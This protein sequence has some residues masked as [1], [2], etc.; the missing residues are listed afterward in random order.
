M[1]F[2][3]LLL[4]PSLLFRLRRSRKALFSGIAEDVFA[5]GQISLFA[6]CFPIFIQKIVLLFV[7]SY[8]IIDDFLWKN[9]G[10][11][12]RPVFYSHFLSPIGFIKT[13][14]KL[15]S[16]FITPF[17]FFLGSL[18]L[19]IF[20]PE[21]ASWKSAVFL[22]LLFTFW[23]KPELETAFRNP[24]ILAEMDFY[25]WL[26]RK[27]KKNK[28]PLPFS[29]PAEVH[30]KFSSDFP[31]LRKTETFL[32]PKKIVLK[33]MDQKP[34]IIFV[35]LESFRAKN[36]GCLGAK[37][38]LSSHFD[39]LSQQG[40]LF[41]SFYANGNMTSRAIISSLFGIPPAREPSY[42]RYYVDIPLIGLPQLLKQ[43]GYHPAT[44]QGSALNFQRFLDFFQTHGFETIYG[45]QDIEKGLTET[46]TGSWGLYDEYLFR[47]SVD[48]LQK[49]N[50]PVFLNLFTITNHCPWDLSASKRIL[51]AESHPFYQTFAYTDWA[52]GQFIDQLRE[53]HLLERS[54]LFIFGDHGQA[55]GEHDPY[56]QAHRT[57]YEE[58]IHVPLLILAEGKLQNP[59]KIDAPCS[60]IDLLPT[61]LDLLELPAVHHSMG[62]SLLREGS[63]PIFFN[64]PLDEGV[65]GC[66]ENQW[67]YL[68]TG[69]KEELFNLDE[70]PEEQKDLKKDQTDIFQ[71]I[72]QKTHDFF[73]SL[74]ALY[75]HRSFA[76]V[77]QEASS[78]QEK[79]LNLSGSL[80][81][82]DQTLEK[83]LSPS[84]IS[85]D[86]SHCILLS[87]VEPVLKSC[88]YLEELK[89]EGVD[90]LSDLEERTPPLRYLMHLNLL[91]CP[92]LIEEKWGPWIASLPSLKELKL[93]CNQWKDLS[94]LAKT[95]PL[96]FIHLVTGPHI[97]EDALAQF[98]KAQPQLGGLCLEDF[99]NAGNRVLK[100]LLGKPMRH[101]GLAN[102]PLLTDEGLASIHSFS[103][104]WLM[105][106][107][108]P[109]IT[110]E[111]LK[112]LK[113]EGLKLF[114]TQC[115]KVNSSLLK[116]YGFHIWS[117]EVASSLCSR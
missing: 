14:N 108:C 117:D 83:N 74:D 103:L 25:R 97:P 31:L 90:D 114:I 78:S 110:E 28:K 75:G 21:T 98:L 84:L 36:V 10:F 92:R 19:S 32:G 77:R 35:Y 7:L 53:A 87:R 70:D 100:A 6:S 93:C 3:S 104:E 102:C 41:S 11:R 64:H 55:L 61:V 81:I 68:A 59:C 86:L 60:Q 111:G 76:P 79:Q 115:P 58:E 26:C 43:A 106:H 2:L 48:W 56:Y 52:L 85:L 38:P 54:I 89:L 51:P 16:P 8:F 49:Q 34:H 39:A 112:G 15:P 5:A 101:I 109:Q 42:M 57:L 96:S 69:R 66:R 17:L 1:Y 27:I 50:Q 33:K 20:L 63:S 65:V 30:R 24:I 73:S 105:L 67:K 13:A 99:P 29:F 4:F 71:N 72:Q 45:I 37:I 82:N 107:N 44:M 113:K 18:F 94:P 116:Q 91:K 47:F 88:P 22:S 12:L 62:R 9:Y 23:K 80:A 40:A 95:A 46:A